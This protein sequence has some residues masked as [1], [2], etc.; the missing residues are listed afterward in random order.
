MPC[1]VH[2]TSCTPYPFPSHPFSSSCHLSL[3]PLGIYS[4]TCMKNLH[5]YPLQHPREYPFFHIHLHENPAPH[6]LSMPRFRSLHVHPAS[7]S[8]STGAGF[9]SS[10]RLDCYGSSAVATSRMLSANE[11]F[12]NGQISADKAL[13]A[14]TKATAASSPRSHEGCSSRLS[15]DTRPLQLGMSE[16]AREVGSLDQLRGRL[17]H[18]R[19]LHHSLPEVKKKST[20]LKGPKRI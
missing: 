19:F 10:T 9:D 8:S 1:S 20:W 15:T 16:V 13:H 2:P 17:S 6:H 12:L 18:L 14:P 4:L 3:S 11:L 7:A 5:D